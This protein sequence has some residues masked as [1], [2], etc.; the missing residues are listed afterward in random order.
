ML[1]H[2][3]GEWIAA[4]DTD[5]GINIVYHIQSTTP[6]EAKM[7]KKDP[8]E[9]LQL[10]GQRQPIPIQLMREVR[11]LRCGGNKR[12]ILDFNPQDRLTLN[13]RFGYGAM[14]G[15][16]TWNGTRESGNGEG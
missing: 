11:V 3:T 15:L 14:T 8:S 12:A 10:L 4:K 6:L 13:N 5:G 9:Q 1:A 16:A 2:R 7:Y